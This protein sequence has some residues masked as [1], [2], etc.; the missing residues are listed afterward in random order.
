MSELQSRM[1]KEREG[2]V[3]VPPHAGEAVVQGA[4]Q[5]GQVGRT[6]VGQFAPLDV[7]PHLFDG[8][9]FRGVARQAFDVQ[10]ATLVGQVRPHRP[11]R[12]R[13]QAIPDQDHA[14]APEVSFQMA[15]K[16]DEAPRRIGAGARLEI[17]AGPA[18]IPA[19]REG[20]RHREPLPRA[21]GVGQDGGL[22]A[23]RP[24]ATDDGLLGDATFVFEDEPGPLAPGVFFTAGHRSAIHCRMAGSSRSRAWRAGRCNDQCSP[25]RR[26]Q[27][28]PA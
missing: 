28:W 16:S 3:G 21:A 17:E 26:Y 11:A 27:T 1:P 25:R 14:T 5:R 19:E 10:P 20:P 18:A 4:T 8:I 23:R 24:R 15:Q 22:A 9:Q 2:Q 6:Q 7:A 13:A 12:V